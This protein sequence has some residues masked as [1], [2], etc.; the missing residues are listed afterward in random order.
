MI[1]NNL[2]NIEGIGF[3]PMLSLIIFFLFFLVMFI[4]VFKADK[5]HLEKMS[6]SPLSDNDDYKF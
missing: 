5:N 1:K 3:Y 2:E 6:Q 4:W